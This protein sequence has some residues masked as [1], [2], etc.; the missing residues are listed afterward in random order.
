VR[1]RRERFF[2]LEPRVGIGDLNLAGPR[3]WDA[4]D[5]IA[6][7]VVGRGCL[8][9]PSVRVGMCWA[10]EYLGCSRHRDHVLLPKFVGRCILNSLN[11]Y[12]L[13]VEVATPQT[14]IVAVVDQYGLR[15]DLDAIA[16]ECS[17]RNYAYF[18]DSP[19]G[20]GQVECPAPRSLARFIGLAKILPIV[21][22][23]L[24]L[25]ND[26]RFIEFVR[27][28][29]GEQSTWSWIVWAVMAL[30]RCRREVGRYSEVA[31]AAYEMYVP[32][33]GGNAW[34]RGNVLRVLERIESIERVHAERLALL[35]ARLGG[36]VLTPD[37]AR[38]AYAAPYLPGDRLE[39]AQE[40]FRREGFDATAYH[41]DVNRNLFA[42]RY[43]KALL[44][45]LNSRVPA[46]AFDRLVGGLD[47]LTSSNEADCATH[48][49]NLI[50]AQVLG[51]EG[52]GRI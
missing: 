10:L 29:R 41:V 16:A 39:A 13:P 40:V 6:A 43:I 14:R 27:R 46:T 45:P 2:P 5:A 19:Y 52:E 4:V 15:Q 35:G 20:L 26:D 47:R 22:G 42:P 36:H 17:R 44:I 12:A 24:L 48:P 30:L 23:A 11:R 1:P 34:L 25:S 9:I 3:S 33:R 8:G 32:A 49:L 38:L 7:R 51:D 18:E 50:E 21:Q 31:D 28:K 37:L